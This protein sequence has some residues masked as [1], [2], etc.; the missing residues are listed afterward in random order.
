LVSAPFSWH[1]ETCSIIH[2]PMFL[3]Q[4]GKEIKIITGSALAHCT[5]KD[6]LCFI[7]RHVSDVNFGSSCPVKLFL[8]STV[9]ELNQHCAFQCKKSKAMQVSQI[10]NELYV[11]TNIRNKL[12]IECNHVVTEMQDPLQGGPGSLEIK[13]PCNCELRSQGVVIISKLFPCD[14]RGIKSVEIYHVIPTLWTKI[15]SL[16]I[17]NTI[18]HFA[19]FENYSEFL[20]LNWSQE[21][22]HINM[23]R[24]FAITDFISDPASMFNKVNNSFLLVDFLIVWN[25]IISIIFVSMVW[26][27]PMLLF[28]TQVRG[29][30][31]TMFVHDLGTEVIVGVI[32]VLFLFL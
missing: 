6:N 15:N 24:P 2:D 18:P 9:A 5:S 14:S 10:E 32:A 20:N 25:V 12:S 16:K 8:G 27:H 19:I 13:V 22:P 21:T 3:A 23:S 26:R 29:V 28:S 4:S 7:P 1:D 31:A 30:D 17:H 11:L